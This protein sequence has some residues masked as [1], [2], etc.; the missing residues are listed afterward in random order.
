MARPAEKDRPDLLHFAPCGTRC[1]NCGKVDFIRYERVI[2]GHNASELCFCGACE[3]E[4]VIPPPPV[5]KPRPDR[6]NLPLRHSLTQRLHREFKEIP[7]LCLTPLEASRL[8][9]VPPAMCQRLLT[10]LVNNG[11]LVRRSD[12]RYLTSE[13]E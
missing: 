12:G 2:N 13:N 5:V 6:R 3:Y 8:F 11:L 1:P 9:G 10:T 7:G 4:W